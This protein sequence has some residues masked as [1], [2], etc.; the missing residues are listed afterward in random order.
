[1]S[2]LTSWWLMRL[3]PFGDTY[4]QQKCMRWL[5]QFRQTGI[6]LFC[7]HDTC[8]VLNLCDQ[9]LWLAKGTLAMQGSAKEVCEG[10][11]A[12]INE[13]AMGI[14]D[15]VVLAIKLKADPAA[16]LNENTA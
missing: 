1:M 13:Q 11:I 5:R 9:A 6:V 4:F 16:R 14:P 12:S 8:A 3:W 7:G 10:Y 15:R 2:M